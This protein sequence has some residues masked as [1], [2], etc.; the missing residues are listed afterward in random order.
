MNQSR[1]DGTEQRTTYQEASSEGRVADDGNAQLSARRRN[2]VL[3]DLERPQRELDLDGRDGVHSV[4]LADRSSTDLRQADALDLARLDILCDIANG[5]LKRHR[6]INTCYPPSV[7]IHVINHKLIIHT[8]LKQIQL[9]LPIQHPQR[10]LHRPLN[11]RLTPI[12][13]QLARHTPALDGQHHFLRVFRVLGEVLIEQVQRVALGCAVDF[14]AVPG[15]G[16]QGERGA[17]C[18]EGLLLR[19]GAHAPCQACEGCELEGW[20]VGGKDH[21]PIRP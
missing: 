1:P 18:L 14:A 8:T 17:H 7:L 3:E 9:L 11:P 2:A 10:L 6:Q 5:L 15:I 12:R 13:G 16:A 19:G 21:V 4:R 20:G